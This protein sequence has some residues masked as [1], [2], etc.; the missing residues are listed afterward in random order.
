[1]FG[2][3]LRAYIVLKSFLSTFI[4]YIEVWDGRFWKMFASYKHKMP[5]IAP[6][7]FAEDIDDRFIILDDEATYGAYM[8]FVLDWR[9]GALT[10]GLIFLP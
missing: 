6:V 5:C 10:L 9:S 8:L 7:C 2:N 4:R 3:N 1:M